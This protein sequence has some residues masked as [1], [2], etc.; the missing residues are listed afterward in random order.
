M[1]L[2]SLACVRIQEDEE[3]EG[4]TMLDQLGMKRTWESANHP[5]LFFNEDGVTLTTLGFFV[6][7][8]NSEHYF[9]LADHKDF[10]LSG[11]ISCL[12]DMAAF[13]CQVFVSVEASQ[14]QLFST[15]LRVLCNGAQRLN[16]SCRAPTL[17]LRSPSLRH[18]F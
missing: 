18:M 5:Y 3:V 15:L 7:S 2:M 13:F 14:G 11:E 4:G 9:R 16:D 17:R 8:L 1:S 6:R 10:C 12:D